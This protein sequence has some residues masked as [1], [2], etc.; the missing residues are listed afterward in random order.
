VAALIETLRHDKWMFVRR[1]AAEALGAQCGAD[2]ATA[3]H[4]AIESKDEDDDVRRAALAALVRCKDPQTPRLLV[5]VLTGESEDRHIRE[6][7]CTLLGATGDHSATGPMSDTI[8]RA[9]SQGGDWIALGVACTR[10]MGAFA[11]AE[12]LLLEL[13]GDSNQPPLQIAAAEALGR[14]CSPAAKAA[15]E[16]AAAEKAPLLKRAA[17]DAADRCSRH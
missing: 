5:A 16:K 3:L 8:R 11:E 7:A 2:A 13:L 1:D 12:K 15:L 4:V 10:A 17:R 6:E 9:R 14:T